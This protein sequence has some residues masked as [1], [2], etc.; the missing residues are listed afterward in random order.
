MQEKLA[1]ALIDD[2]FVKVDALFSKAEIDSWRGVA[3]ATLDDLDDEHRERFRSNGSLC[4]IAELP[5]FA[6]LIGDQRINHLPLGRAGIL[7]FI[8]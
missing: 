1:G 7:G 2:G 4:N 3:Q 5:S 8:Q 6:P